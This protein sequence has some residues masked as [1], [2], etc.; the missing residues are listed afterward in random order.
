MYC[1]V[2]VSDARIDVPRHSWSQDF[3][4]V[5]LSQAS[6][7]YPATDSYV[8]QLKPDMNR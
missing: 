5:S 8:S 4:S 6:V 7:V 3:Y 1:Q 2:V